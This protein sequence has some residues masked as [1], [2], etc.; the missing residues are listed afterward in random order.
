MTEVTIPTIKKFQAGTA[1]MVS[2]LSLVVMF[3][4]AF[5]STPRVVVTPK[6]DMCNIRHWVEDITV[7]ADTLNSL[8]ENRRANG[9]RLD[10]A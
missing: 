8:K 5:N 6:Q 9:A 7:S 10:P 3:N 4:S 1:D 2:S